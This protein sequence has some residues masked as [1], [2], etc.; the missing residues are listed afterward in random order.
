MTLL[1]SVQFPGKCLYKMCLTLYAVVKD[2][3]FFRKLG[4]ILVLCFVKYIFTDCGPMNNA[5]L[6]VYTYDKTILK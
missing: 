6:T 1:H 4:K 2:P 5:G 3:P